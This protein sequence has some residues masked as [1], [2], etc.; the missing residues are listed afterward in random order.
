[1]K[2]E[3]TRK[4]WYLSLWKF[5]PLLLKINFWERDWTLAFVSIQFWD[6]LIMS[7]NPQ[8][9]IL[10]FF[11]NSWG[12]SYTKF[13]VIDIKFRFA[14]SESNLH[15]DCKLPKYFVTDCMKA[16]ICILTTLIKIQIFGNSPI[17]VEYGKSIKKL[18][19]STV[20]NFLISIFNLSLK[21]N[22]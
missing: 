4:L 22:C 15:E 9:L 13:I 5:R 19:P 14:C 20:E 2:L 8:I 11:S 6:F 3:K 17:L 21:E 16:F 7:I 18:P 1:M 10:R 12:N